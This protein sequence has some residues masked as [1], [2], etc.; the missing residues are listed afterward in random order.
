MHYHWILEFTSRFQYNNTKKEENQFHEKRHH[1]GKIILQNF[2]LGLGIYFQIFNLISHQL[3]GMQDR[4][5][6]IV[7]LESEPKPYLCPKYIT[8][9][10]D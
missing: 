10:L 2:S 7:S 3:M 8:S 1:K 9:S 4:K 5:H 6:E